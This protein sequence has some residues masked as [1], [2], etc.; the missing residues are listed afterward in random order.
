MN[1]KSLRTAAVLMA[2]ALLASLILT[3][4]PIETRAAT[5]YFGTFFEEAGPVG[6][7]FADSLARAANDDGVIL[8]T[9][10]WTGGAND[11]NWTSNGNWSG[12]GGAG[13]DDDLVFPNSA[14]RKSN[15]NDFAINTRFRTITISGN[16]YLITG[17]QLFL[18]LGITA[19][20]TATTGA[21][22]TLGMNIVLDA[23]QTFQTTSRLLNLN[24]VVNL[25]ARNLTVTGDGS[26]VFNNTI[27][28]T[29]TIN[30]SGNGTLVING[31]SPNINAIT[32]QSGVLAVNGAVG[33][34]S[35][36]GGTLIGGGTTGFVQGS[37][38]NGAGTIAPGSGGTT[39]DI[40]AANAGVAMRSTVG[41]EIDLNG[42]TAGTQYDRLAVSGGNLNIN[43]AQ[44]SGTCSFTPAVGQQFTIATVSGAGNQVVGQF[45][46]GGTVVFGS[47]VFSITYN[48]TSVVL[49]AQ[50]PV[51]SLTWD[52][53][54]T[55]NNWS[56][57]ANWN[58]DAAPIDGVDLV[59]PAGAPADSLNMVNDIAGLDLGSITFN[60]SGYTINTNAL[61]L[62]GG[63]STNSSGA[64][65][66]ISAPVT[67]TAPATFA[68]TGTTSLSLGSVNQNGFPMTV[69]A[70][71]GSVGFGNVVSGAGGIVKNGAGIMAL[72]GSNTFT[73]L[74]QVNA[75]TVAV[76]NANAL[77]ATGATNATNIASG[78]S[79]HILN[80]LT[81]AETLTVAG[82]GNGT[83]AIQGEISCAT[84][85]GISGP[86]QLTGNTTVS[87]I[88]TIN[89]SGS[90][91]ETGGARSLTKIGAGTLRLSAV[92]SYQGAT[93]V[94]EGTLE[95]AQTFA[96][97]GDLVVGDGAGGAN[98]DVVRLFSALNSIRALTVN[99]SGQFDVNGANGVNIGSLSGTGQFAM[100]GGTAFIGGLP[101]N[102][103]FGGVMTGTGTLNKTG[104]GSLTLTGANTFTG[105][106]N[107][108]NGVL[109]VNG[110]LP[111]SLTLNAGTLGG[112]GT[113]GP[114]TTPAG[115]PTLVSPGASP[116]SLTVTGAA[117]LAASSTFFVELGG[118]APGTQYDRLTAGGTLN[119]GGATLSGAFL[120]GYNPA[121]G[122]TF[123]IAQ[124]SGALSGQFA[125]GTTA[126]LGGR[127]FSITYNANSVVL[128]ALAPRPPFDFDGDGKTDVSIFRPVDG[129]W[130][131]TKSTDG[132]FRVYSFGGSTDVLAPGDWTG[133][134]LADIAIY[135][136]ASG[137]WFVQRSEDNTFF[138][139]PFGAAGDVAV[140]GD[141]DGDGKTDAAVF[142]PS[143][144]TW[145]ISNSG[146]SGTSIVSFGASTDQPLTADF[147]G[148]GKTDIAVFR[149]SDGSWWYLRSTDGTFRV[150]RFGLGTDKTVPGDWTGDG[151]ADI[152][153]FRPTTGEWFVQ[154]SEDGSFFSFPFGTNGDIPAP[155]DYDGDGKTDAAVF[156]AGTWFISRSTAGTLITSFG[157]AGDRPVPNAF[158]R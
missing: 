3:G 67:L 76:Q 99:S 52:G 51:T 22:P 61:T 36:T 50:G 38:A 85:C 103:T 34:I 35:L 152:A 88:G 56:E 100:N 106:T 148:D 90:I 8:A 141:Y 44:L 116:G 81:I 63:A 16:D 146:G 78:G 91:T 94:N 55:T 46:Q 134:G 102:T 96:I 45:A 155:G 30:K 10:T 82:A 48:L 15:V 137:T 64:S 117:A 73:G 28:G 107:I 72:S 153:V 1:V 31:N 97:V 145:F 143:T 130:W 42:T 139:F 75:G 2:T 111:G 39:T 122:T 26:T 87:A 127:R 86:I 128:T 33:T 12:I 115:S 32:L 133:D 123:T 4:L 113:V 49:T 54:G 92:N 121:P 11:I 158:V 20:Q 93:V 147:D 13:A 24:G 25:N 53:G 83:G 18:L 95:P 66:A 120:N 150:Y 43:G 77:G 37:L 105:T 29:G 68:T 104:G 27:S 140:P 57:A 7:R 136:P 80:N 65:C 126:T 70:S 151:K 109:I 58:P 5:G 62:S 135:R 9:E 156:R 6:A 132:S 129:S 41:L 69:N 60:A 79:L 142:R 101:V 71:S 119:L 125:Q 138:S 124:S 149:Q 21:H 157:S 110:V 14:A 40:L 19:N 17:N 47:Q 118:P 23:D 74:L 89:L 84:G 144:A 108:Q 131:Y 59:F 112:S 114:L 98:A 154:R